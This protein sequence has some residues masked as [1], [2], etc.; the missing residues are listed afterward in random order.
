MILKKG[1]FSG[2]KA[3][4]ICKQVSR[5]EFAQEESHPRAETLLTQDEINNVDFVLKNRVR[6]EVYIVIA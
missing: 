1:W 2:L 6:K 5:E 3:K 4:K